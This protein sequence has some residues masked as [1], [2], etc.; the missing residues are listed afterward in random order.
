MDT[1]TP[2]A[3]NHRQGRDVHVYPMPVPKTSVPSHHSGVGHTTSTTGGGGGGGGDW[4]TVNLPSTPAER[5][6]YL[7]AC[8]EW[9]VT[10]ATDLDSNDSWTCTSLPPELRMDADGGE[11]TGRHESPFF[12]T[13]Q[14]GLFVSPSELCV[15]LG[16]PCILCQDWVDE[17]QEPVIANPFA[18]RRLV[19]V[20]ERCRANAPTVAPSP[21]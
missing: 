5:N 8:T 1:H 16:A 12:T 20:C 19:L 21:L 7:A 17:H 2:W 3:T 10:C 18:Q 15:L 11:A 9:L 14:S 4:T 6:A 13:P